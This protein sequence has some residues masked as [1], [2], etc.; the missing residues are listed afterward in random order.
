MPDIETP[1]I[2]LAAMKKAGFEVMEHGDLA[3][4]G[5]I[6][7]YTLLMPKWTLTDFKVRFSKNQNQYEYFF[8]LIIR[9]MV[10]K[11]E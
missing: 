7:W 10:Y 2:A 11:S 9:V 8:N 4:K 1:E 3:P 6:P 5:D